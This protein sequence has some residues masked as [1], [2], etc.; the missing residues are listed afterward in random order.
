MRYLLLALML[1]VSVAATAYAEPTT[2]AVYGEA[3]VYE[4]DVADRHLQYTTHQQ[5]GDDLVL[6]S[7]AIV[8][9]DAFVI[10]GA[11]PADRTFAPGQYPVVLTLTR[12]NEGDLRV[13]YARVEFGQGQPVRWEPASTFSA[14]SGIGAFLDADAVS[15]ATDDYDP[16]GKLVLGAVALAVQRD[17]Y[18]SAV[19]VDPDSG[20]DAVVFTTGYGE[21]TFTTY[22]G[23]DE[24]DTPV[25]LVADFNVL[26]P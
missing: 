14:E 21:G 6:T 12:D 2:E 1:T 5:Q 18:W 13:A 4:A 26:A 19:L 16:Y 10:F 9:S 17:E 3:Q 23:F 7:G 11:Q 24:N 22:F 8:T 25:A 15:H 20:A